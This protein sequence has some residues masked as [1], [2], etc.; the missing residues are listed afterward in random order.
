MRIVRERILWGLDEE[1]S[2]K[3]ANI[4]SASSVKQQLPVI[5]L[6]WASTG[7]FLLLELYEK[8]IHKKRTFNLSKNTLVESRYIACI[9]KFA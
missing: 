9:M 1:E 4:G 5:W 8:I 6:G 3:E 2:G 7:R